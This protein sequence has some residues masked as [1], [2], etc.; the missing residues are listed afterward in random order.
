MVKVFLSQINSWDNSLC[1]KIFRL[2]GKKVADILMVV[3]SKT[4]DGYL[5]ALIGLLVFVFDFTTAL[6]FVPAGLVAF[7]LELSVHTLLKQKT[8]RNRPFERVSGIK[9]LIK[10]PDKFSFPS[11]HTAAAFLMATLTSS[12]YPFITLPCFLFAALV[13]FSRV[14]NGLHYPS[15]VIAGTVLGITCANIGLAFF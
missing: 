8:K 4:G 15:D 11:G 9:F 12:F 13:G 14:Y 5:Y 7:A 2:N 6:K 10:P 3:M 1:L